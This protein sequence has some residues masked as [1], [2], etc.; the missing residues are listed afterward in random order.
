MLETA[1]VAEVACLG[2]V[3]TRNVARETAASSAEVASAKAAAYASAAAEAPVPTTNP[4]RL[5][6]IANRRGVRG[7]IDAKLV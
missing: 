5:T 2:K 1:L 4:K 6:A 3:P 7:E